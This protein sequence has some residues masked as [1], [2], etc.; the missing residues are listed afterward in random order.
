MSKRN[1]GSG[2]VLSRKVGARIEELLPANLATADNVHFTAQAPLSR[3]F[4]PER[5]VGGTI[6]VSGMVGENSQFKIVLELAM[7]KRDSSGTDPEDLEDWTVTTTFY[8]TESAGPPDL[9]PFHYYAEWHEEIGEAAASD[10]G[11][12]DLDTI[13]DHYRY[14]GADGVATVLLTEIMAN[15]GASAQSSRQDRVSHQG[16]LAMMGS[17]N[18]ALDNGRI[19]GTGWK[20]DWAQVADLIGPDAE[21]V[22]NRMSVETAVPEKQ[23]RAALKGVDFLADEEASRQTASE[24]SINRRLS[25]LLEELDSMN[26][27]EGA[28][29]IDLAQGDVAVTQERLESIIRTYPD[30]LAAALDDG[31]FGMAR[32]IAESGDESYAKMVMVYGFHELYGAIGQLQES[33]RAVR[34]IAGAITAFGTAINRGNSEM[35]QLSL[36]RASDAFVTVTQELVE[37]G[38]T[39]LTDLRAVLAYH[40]LTAAFETH[41]ETRDDLRGEDLAYYF[42]ATDR[43]IESARRQHERA[44]KAR[45]AYYLFTQQK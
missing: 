45:E 15:R 25:S 32:T 27:G 10:S 30:G 6:N 18:T 4:R 40:D 9:D 7:Q 44:E 28:P 24:Q 33:D 13:G 31:N 34:N 36:K 26:R 2:E 19:S 43:L 41:V 22:L 8:R 35:A 39:R 14:G 29:A 17:F 1:W 42:D 37:G 20:L 12:I 11:V 5:A 23:R 16:S 3:D 38:Q 21:T